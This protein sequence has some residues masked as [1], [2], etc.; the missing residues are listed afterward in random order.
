MASSLN[1]LNQWVD[2]ICSLTEAD[3]IYWCDGSKEEFDKLVEDMIKDG[4]LLKLNEESFPECYLHRSDPE[5]VARVEHL[6][7]VCSKNEADAGQNNNWMEPDI[8]KKKMLNFFSGC[9]KS[10]TLYVIPYCMGPLNSNLSRHGVEITD[11]PY[12]VINMYLMTRMGKEALSEIEKKGTFVKG[13]H[14]TGEL[15]PNK[16]FIMHFP[17]DLTIMS[18]GSGYGGNALLGKKCHALRIASYQARTEGWLAE[19]MLI[20]GIENPQGDVHYLSLIHI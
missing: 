16:R 15:D 14:S 18:Y 5:D 19:H 20:V 6:T 12:V 11:S 2:E 8:A 3:S 13:I 9:M 4:S 17:E 10:R 7:Y 1:T